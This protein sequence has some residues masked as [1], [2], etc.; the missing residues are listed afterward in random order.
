M[1]NGERITFAEDSFIHNFEIYS[2]NKLDKTYRQELFFKNKN[3]YAAKWNKDWFPHTCR[4]SF[5]IEAL[6][7]SEYVQKR[8]EYV[9]LIESLVLVKKS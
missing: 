2:F 9:L 5:A 8:Q 1:Q 7:D 6:G 4:P 3:K